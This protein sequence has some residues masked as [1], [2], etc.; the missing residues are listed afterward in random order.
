MAESGFGEQ[1]TAR[2]DDI[3]SPQN[4][5]NIIEGDEAGTTS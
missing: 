5:A 3:P 1:E 2:Q 4:A